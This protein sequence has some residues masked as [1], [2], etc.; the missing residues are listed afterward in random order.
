M[1]YLR[2]NNTSLLSTLKPVVS[3]LNHCWWYI[4][5]SGLS[6]TEAYSA[7]VARS[8]PRDTI[9][10][11]WQ[12]AIKKFVDSDAIPD[13]R[14]GKP[15]FLSRLGDSV[16]FDWTTFFAI[17]SEDL[18]TSVIGEILPFER[19]YFEPLDT[20]PESV[21][22]IARDVDSAYQDFGFRDSWMFKSVAEWLHR[23]SLPCDE[24]VDWPP[25]G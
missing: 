20:L 6:I 1:R 9:E 21:V 5:G 17:E 23:R 18:P 12:D 13:A 22:L 15:G 4:G 2:T 7:R 8:I 14:V 24:V 16:D 25:S 19:R 3:A 10:V 11:Y